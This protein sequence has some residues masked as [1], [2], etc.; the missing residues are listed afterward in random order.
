VSGDA[1]RPSG[2]TPDDEGIPDLDEGLP[3][4][5]MTGDAQE[6][7]PLPSDRPASFDFGVTAAEQR[8]GESISQR[9]EREEPDPTAEDAR[10]SDDQIRAD[11]NPVRLIGEASLDETDLDGELISDAEPASEGGMS[12][13]EASVHVVD[14]APGAVG[15]PDSYVP[16]MELTDDDTTTRR[17]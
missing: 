14:D 15:G 7:M 3:E 16:T 8:Q 9:V 1:A 17:Q 2:R 13:E 5:A 6:G 10:S 12:A 4:K 11:N